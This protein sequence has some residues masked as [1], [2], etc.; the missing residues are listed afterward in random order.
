MSFIGFQSL[1]ELDGS[2]LY[3]LASVLESRGKLLLN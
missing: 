1:E 3:I 2:Y